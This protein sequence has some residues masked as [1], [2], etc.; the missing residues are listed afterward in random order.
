VGIGEPEG[1]KED[2]KGS[3]EGAKEQPQHEEQQQYSYPSN[4]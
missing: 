4:C 2:S 3:P 1:A